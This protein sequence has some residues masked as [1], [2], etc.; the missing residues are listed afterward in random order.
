M[1]VLSAAVCPADGEL[2]PLLSHKETPLES[3]NGTQN[4]KYGI[5]SWWDERKRRHWSGWREIE[6]VL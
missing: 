2:F 3:M 4:G 5:F 6:V 1:E